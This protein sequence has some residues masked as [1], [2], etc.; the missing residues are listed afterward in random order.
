MCTEN[1]KKHKISDIIFDEDEAY[2]EA[3]RMIK[4]CAKRGGTTMH[5]SH[6]RLKSLPPEIYYLKIKKLY[7]SRYVCM[8]IS[9]LVNN[10][11]SLEYLQIW[12]TPYIPDNI[13]NLKNLKFLL[14]FGIKSETLPDS[15]GE[16][17]LE[18]LFLEGSYNKLPQTIG[19][20]TNLKEL[21]LYSKN[22]KS[23]PESL[24]KC[25]KLKT[26]YIDSDKLKKLPESFIQLRNL[27]DIHLDTFN[28]KI[29]P[30]AFGNLR[31]LKDLDIFSGALTT[32]PESMGNLKNFKSLN[33]DAYNVMEQP[34]FLKRFSYVKDKLLNVGR[35][36]QPL[37][38][39]RHHS[40]YSPNSFGKKYNDLLY[41]S[42][43]HRRQYLKSRSIKELESLLLCAPHISDSTWLDRDIVD[44][45]MCQRYTILL[46][47]F[48]PTQKNI[49]RVVEVSD[50][51]LKSWEEGITRARKMMEAI[52]DKA[53]DKVS[54]NKRYDVEIKLYPQVLYKNS[55][56]KEW[57][58]RDD[59]HNILLSYSNKDKIYLCM[60]FD[61]DPE[62]KDHH[63]SDLHI[64]LKENWNIEPP[65]PKCFKDHYICYAIHQLFDD[66]YFAL[67]DIA[68]INNIEVTVEVKH[69]GIIGRF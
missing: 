47:Q 42:L 1:I 40:Y 19:N 54:F 62:N 4:K 55:K 20:L 69:T 13:C 12:N 5:F 53:E 52:Y 14:A 37:V 8:D 48:K 11:V 26:I 65:M 61:Y 23:L 34:L 56:T 50:K 36:L 39:E 29:L 51:F 44:D 9:D 64:D 57:Q 63:F 35:V 25:I 31:L 6:L 7:I 67:Q 33:I 10:L 22:L 21:D 60:Q 45:I 15:I 27:R 30:F 43:D 17:P 32:L 38:H 41:M 18:S 46:K 3:Q 59:I 2:L 24:G 58:E 66:I 28:L 49:L 16:C 68:R